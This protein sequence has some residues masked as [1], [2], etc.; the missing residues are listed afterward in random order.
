[1]RN[2]LWIHRPLIN[3]QNVYEW[4]EAA[5]IKKMMPPSQLHMTV[6]T[7]RHP[8]EWG[9]LKLRTNELVIPIG[10]K[11]VQIF[12]YTIKALTFDHADIQERHKEI[13]AMFPKMDHRLMRPH[14]SLYK[15]G[16]M[17]KLEYQGELIFGPEEATIFDETNVG[18]IKHVKISEKLK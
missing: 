3:W 13:L 6:V 9:D 14:V 10:H 4:G 2:P 7:V 15:G 18:G 5:G 11:P 8:T 1:M 16:R 12:A 17:P